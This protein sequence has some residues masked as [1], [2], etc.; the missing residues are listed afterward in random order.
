[1]VE[2]SK[3]HFYL[4]LHLF[5]E[6]QNLIDIDLNNFIEKNLIF[7]VDDITFISDFYTDIFLD[8]YAI[9]ENMIF[10]VKIIIKSLVHILLQALHFKILQNSRKE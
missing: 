7:Q 10:R 1:M 4:N 5:L 6:N 2:D 3:K 8:N 9:T